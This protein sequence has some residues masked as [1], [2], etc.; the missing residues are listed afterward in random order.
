MEKGVKATQVGESFSNQQKFQN[1]R[2]KWDQFQP[3][4]VVPSELAVEVGKFFKKKCTP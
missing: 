1:D 2:G 4:L 3:I